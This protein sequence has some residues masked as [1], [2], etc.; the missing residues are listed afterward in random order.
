MKEREGSLGQLFLTH[1]SDSKRWQSDLLGAILASHRNDQYP[2]T[3]PDDRLQESYKGSRASAFRQRILHNLRYRGILD[4]Y[5][6]I[7]EAHKATFRWIFDESDH[8]DRPWKN[9]SKFLKDDTNIYWISGKAGAGKSTLMKYLFENPRTYQLLSSTHVPCLQRLDLVYAGF[10][11][12]NSGTVIQMSRE[13]LLRTLLHD[14]LKQCE[15]VLPVIFPDLWEAFY[16]L[17]SFPD[18]DWTWTE[19]VRAFRRLL[20]TPGKRFFF[21]IDGLD[22]FDNDESKIRELVDFLKSISDQDNVKLCVASRPWVIFEDSFRH[23]SSLMLENLTFADI[24]DYVHINLRGNPAYWDLE[25]EE[26]EYASCLIEEIARKSAGVFLWV[27]LVVASLLSG[28]TNG[29]RIVD[30]QQR[31][32]ALPSDLEQLFSKILSSIDPLYKSH[33]CRLF[34][35]VRIWNTFNSGAMEATTFL[36]QRDTPLTLLQLYFADLEDVRSALNYPVQVWTNEEK[37]SKLERMRRRVNSRCKGLLESSSLLNGEE[38]TVQ[39]LHRTVK[40]FIEQE[41]TRNELL[42]SAGAS[43]DPYLHLCASFLFQTKIMSGSSNTLLWTYLLGALNSAKDSATFSSGS[44]VDSLVLILDDLDR[45][46]R[47]LIE[48]N[49][50]PPSHTLYEPCISR[51]GQKVH[52]P[53]YVASFLNVALHFGLN[54]YIEEKIVQGGLRALP[55]S[56]CPLLIC[57]VDECEL[58]SLRI[59][60]QPPDAIERELK[61]SIVMTL[62]KAGQDP[63]C[64]FAGKS[65]LYIINER[66][67]RVGDIGGMWQ[68]ISKLLIQHGA[69]ATNVATESHS[70]KYLDIQLPGFPHVEVV[71]PPSVQKSGPVEERRQKGN[72][73][74]TIFKCISRRS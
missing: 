9:Y 15:D 65:P 32:L 74:A 59:R 13:G 45:V 53:M 36:S 63:N 30:L 40:D 43:Y 51:I 20:K 10:F 14:S 66:M 27:T 57:A 55:Q 1:I 18:A 42:H 7:S 6:R 2:H 49:Q 56:A 41:D 52:R 28:I 69:T 24:K 5:D 73:L 70:N 26:P 35:L 54:W 23:S 3:V 48:N 34:M 61:I 4:R 29:D 46:V 31:L 38:I 12:W 68:Q 21:F 44:T 37:Q 33:A 62:L 8:Q 60:L 22:E 71:L 11:F 16:L 72:L 50:A 17:E 19:L 39:Y 67:S 47:Q 58:H 64:S 25:V